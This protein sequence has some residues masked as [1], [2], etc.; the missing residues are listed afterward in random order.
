MQ[1]T[2]I[3]HMVIRECEKHMQEDVIL[4][5]NTSA[6]PIT[7]IAKA[8]SRPKKVVGT[9]DAPLLPRVQYAGSAGAQ[10][11]DRTPAAR[12]Q[13]VWRSAWR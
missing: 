10:R 5:S 4:A 9:G 13:K 8:L 11:G 2:N 6:L 7:K 1:D 12:E 3:K